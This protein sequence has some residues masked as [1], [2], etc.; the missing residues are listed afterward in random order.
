MQ[1]M[2]NI[3]LRLGRNMLHYNIALYRERMNN[4]APT[5]PLT[6]T[7]YRHAVFRKMVIERLH[8]GK[9]AG[10]TP[11]QVVK[12]I[13]DEQRAMA[14]AIV[15]TGFIDAATAALLN[16]QQKTSP[17]PRYH[18]SPT[19]AT[20]GI[21]QIMQR[22]SLES[23][24]FAQLVTQPD[25]YQSLLSHTVDNAPT[26][27]SLRDVKMQEVVDDLLR[28]D[29]TGAPQVI[30]HLDAVAKGM[31]VTHDE[32]AVMFAPDGILH[33]PLANA[34]AQ[35]LP[36]ASEPR[37]D[38]LVREWLQDR[39]AS[40]KIVSELAANDGAAY[41]EA[42]RRSKEWHQHK[43]ETSTSASSHAATMTPAEYETHK[44]REERAEDIAYTIN[45]ALACTATDFIDP[46]VGNLTQ[47][48]LGKRISI[49]CGHDHSKDGKD[50]HHHHDHDHHHHDH[51][52]DH[53]HEHKHEHEHKSGGNLTHWWAGEVVGDFGAVPVTIAF[54]RYA[55]G[56]MNSIRQ[57][58]EPV[59]GPVFRKG[60]KRSAENWALKQHLSLDSD[61]CREKENQ[62][63]E[64]EVRHLPQALI[65][66]ASSVAINLATQK[67]LGNK[68]PLWQLAVGKAV[69]AS[70]SAGLVVGGRAI[71]PEAAHNW[72]RF[73]SKNLFLPVTKAV[74]KVVGVDE[75]D[76]DSMASH[77]HEDA[78]NDSWEERVKDDTAA[79][80]PARKPV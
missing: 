13:A 27:P 57:C 38:A 67:G 1:W 16:V 52:H 72:D 36:S 62:I 4:T 78:R 9:A 3:P 54:Q 31:M 30:A 2:C 29:N 34:L 77:H 22:R 70:I 66:T 79:T 63:Y 33:A 26:T 23:L 14:D 15:T 71:V 21:R 68:G 49:G 59:L 12:D 46:F 41:L 17:T 6:M 56:F 65:W 35:R 5:T 45:H 50:H 47:K 80:T 69:G 75:K 24:T 58:M 53:D 18:I 76:I 37:A 74:G 48:Y 60:A 8:Q 51:G 32:L 19:H 73:T 44:T 55:P 61:A 20:E 42:V 25:Y 28:V 64:H 10:H 11:Q 40:A 39:E 7:S 43:Y